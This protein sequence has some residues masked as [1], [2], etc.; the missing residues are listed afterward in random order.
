VEVITSST[1]F[2]TARIRHYYRLKGYVKVDQA[3]LV[4]PLRETKTIAL[5]VFKHFNTRLIGID[6]RGV[7]TRTA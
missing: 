5:K 3:V 6:S 2:L 7:I 4:T 1:K